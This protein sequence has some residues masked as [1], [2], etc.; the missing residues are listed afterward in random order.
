MDVRATTKNDR[1]N[2]LY[3]LIGFIFFF[4][5]INLPMPSKHIMWL[6]KDI[7]T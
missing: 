6:R 4:P 3:S 7:H 1:I 2:V 5:S